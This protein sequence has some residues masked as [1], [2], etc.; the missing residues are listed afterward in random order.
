MKCKTLSTREHVHTKCFQCQK[1]SKTP[2]SE[3]CDSILSQRSVGSS[4]AL[5]QVQY[6]RKFR[7]HFSSFPCAHKIRIQSSSFSSLFRLKR[8]TKRNYKCI[9]RL[10]KSLFLRCCNEQFLMYARRERFSFRYTFFLHFCLLLPFSEH[11]TGTRS[12]KARSEGEGK[13]YSCSCVLE[14]SALCVN[15]AS[16][17]AL[18]RLRNGFLFGGKNR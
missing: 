12:R 1:R 2:E 5:L 11:K 4:C 17:G 6:Q 10:G 14:M 18:R 8:K 15:V 7:F 16:P 13:M 3:N 9:C